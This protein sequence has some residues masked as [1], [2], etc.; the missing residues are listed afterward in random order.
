VDIDP[1]VT[2]V[3]LAVT[4]MVASIVNTIA[5]GGSFL[6][7]PLLIAVGVPPGVANG[8]VRVGVLVQSVASSLT[9]RRRGV[10]D[11]GAFL[12]LV[13]PMCV[14]AVGGAW[15]ATRLPDEDLRPVFGV[16]FM[17]W[18]AVLVVRPG[19]FLDPRAEPVRPGLGSWVAAVLI[20][21]YGGFLQAGVGFPLMALLIP[22]LG[23]PAV[24]ANAVKV[25]LILVYTALALP[26]FVMAGQVAW[27]E[28]ACLAAGSLAGGWI[29]ARW[30]IRA[31]APL[32]RWFVVI[33]VAMSGAL[34]TFA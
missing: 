20:G 27:A 2:F 3:V 32:V 18:A 30:Q 25:L 12:P 19:R 13:V 24:R 7:L 21:I 17:V 10:R 5:G 28:G 34:M 26:V 1:I 4:A 15:L 14:G 23:Y 11:P 8:T 31:G 22:V 6:V 33:T 29:G 16:A 9:F